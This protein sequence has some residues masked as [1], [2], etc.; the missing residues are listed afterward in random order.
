M[1]QSSQIDT[2]NVIILPPR[3]YFGAIV[4]NVL[5]FLFWPMRLMAGNWIVVV[6]ILLVIG[7][8]VLS[9]MSER[10]FIR[11]ETA[12]NP[13]NPATTLVKSGP[14]RYSRN[15]MYVGLTAIQLGVALALNSLWGIILLIPT[16]LIMHF[17]VILREE[18]YLERLFG[19]KYLAY[20]QSVRRWL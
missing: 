20:K 17:G 16:L 8:V 14:F 2:P 15:P 5:L 18:A 10:E 12:V 11:R 6:G 7:G 1:T 13:H 19:E 9:L 3:L 4:I